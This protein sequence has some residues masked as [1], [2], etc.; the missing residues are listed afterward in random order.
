MQRDTGLYLEDMLEAAARISG[1][2]AGR[3]FATFSSDPRPIDAV[4]RNLEIFGEAAKRVPEAVRQRAADVEWRKIAGM[5]DVLA[6]AYFQI[7]LAIVWDAA[8]H[9]VP[10][11]V[12]PIRR[13]L[14]GDVDF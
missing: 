1:Y 3:D 8:H 12:E 14:A 13:L 6:H 11:C 9:K 10:S 2:I 7:D 4:I 5:R